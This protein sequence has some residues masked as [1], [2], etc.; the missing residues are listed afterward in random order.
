M[1]VGL[2]MRNITCLLP[3][4]PRANSPL[5]S[6]GHRECQVMWQVFYSHL[7][8]KTCVA[9]SPVHVLDHIPQEQATGLARA[10]VRAVFSEESAWTLLR[11]SRTERCQSRCRC[12][13]FRPHAA[14]LV[15]ALLPS[16]PPGRELFTAKI[17]KDIHSVVLPPSFG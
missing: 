17:Y 13:D 12:R 15:S 16:S 5:G 9:C 2:T 7:S 8:L 6:K 14:R 11:S 3:P 1:F 4:Q 10:A